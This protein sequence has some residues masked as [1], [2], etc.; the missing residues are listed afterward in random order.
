[1]KILPAAA[2]AKS[3]QVFRLSSFRLFAGLSNRPRKSDLL[4][5]CNTRRR[6]PEA[7]G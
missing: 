6:Q 1:M 7:F 2:T 5:R 4:M 3:P